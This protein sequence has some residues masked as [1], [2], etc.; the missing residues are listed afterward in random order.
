MM[1]VILTIIGL[2]VAV[3]AISCLGVV[4]TEMAKRKDG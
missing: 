2:I 4:I 1:Y 3:F